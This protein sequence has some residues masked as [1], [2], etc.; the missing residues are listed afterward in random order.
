MNR[1]FLALAGFFGAVSVILGSLA[2]H[3]FKNMLTPAQ[4]EIFKLGVQYQMYHALALLGVAV[5]LNYQKSRLLVISGLLFSV[6]ILF[7]SG[8]MYSITYFGL[9]NIGTAPIGGFAFIFAWI[10]LI[11]KAFRK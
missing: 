5:W 10:L 6:G 4:I 2:S 7:F 8:T 9:P 1:V 11:V 3:A